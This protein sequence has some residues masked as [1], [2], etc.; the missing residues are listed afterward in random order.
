M[1]F[2]FAILL[3]LFFILLMFTIATL[4]KLKHIQR[5][6]AHIVDGDFTKKMNTKEMGILTDICKMVNAFMGNM[7]R[8]IA[9]VG[10]TGDKIK[11]HVLQITQNAEYINSGIKQNAQSIAE[12]ATGFESQAN[13]VV[14]AFKMTEKIGE[15]FQK[16][17][18]STETTKGQAIIG[19]GTISKSVE[20][21]DQLLQS[22]NENA[23]NSYYLS[24]RISHLE[25]KAQE[26]H[27]ITESVRVI[28]ENTNLLALNA[29]IEAARAGE[30]G[31][32][33][34]V[35]ANEVKKLAEQASQYAQEIEILLSSILQEINTLADEIHKDTEQI[36]NNILHANDAKKYFDCAISTT[37]DTLSSIDSICYLAKDEANVIQHIKDLMKNISENA[38]QCS[39]GAQE[40]S[41]TTQQQASLVED[42][43]GSLKELNHM[44]GEI[45]DIIHGFVK[46]YEI[47]HEIDTYIQQGFQVLKSIASDRTLQPFERNTCDRKLYDAYT[48]HKFFEIICLFDIHGE[49]VGIG[50]DK[51]LYDESLYTN[52]AHR[53]YFKKGIAGKD[54]VSEPYISLDSNNYCIAMST[55]VKDSF[56][57]IIGVLMADL[58]LG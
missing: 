49:T 42:M 53:E 28:S 56:G 7:R 4:R 40:A 16:I 35:V 45:K 20:V 44:T 46:S 31:K 6:M 1:N 12:I 52:F 26:I 24:K 13:D 48:K 2:I 57:K 18:F 17:V 3:G 30:M 51:T 5:K 33:F 25:N 19:M 14:Q 36:R 22:L 37:K 10:S 58:T 29:S 8:F 9:I 27:V 21:Y 41:A 39:A 38:Q 55:P 32:G 15:D 34:A 23:E 11:K 43:F 50:I 47:D 54:Y